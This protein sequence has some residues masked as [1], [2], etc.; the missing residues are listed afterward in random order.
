MS[1]AYALLALNLLTTRQLPPGAELHIRLTTPISSY[2]SRAG[3]HVDAV[4]IAPVVSNGEIV[5]PAGSLVSGNLKSVQRV[6]FGLVHELAGFDLEF[7]AITTPDGERFP[8]SAR[9]QEVENARERL[10]RDG[11]I[12]GYR[13]T[14]SL[15]YRTGGY[16]RTAITWEMHAALAVWAVK[17]LLLQV[18]EPEIYY[19]VG[20]ELTLALTG[21]MRAPAP[22]SSPAPSL[23]TDKD[24]AEIDALLEAV[25]ARTYAAYSN[26]PSDLINVMFIGS[27]EDVA[28]AFEAAGWIEPQQATLRTNIRRIRAVAD[29]R[30]DR[31]APMSNLLVQDQ[32]AD[33]SWQK[34]FNDVSQRHHIR[35]WMQTETWNGKPVWVGAATHD[36]DFA[37]WR[38]G[39]PM[40][41]KIAE[42]VDDE[43]DKVVNDLVF[44]TCA[45]LLDF[46]ERAHIPTFTHNATGDPMRTDTRLAIVQVK[47]CAAP[48][49]SLQFTSATLP[50]HGSKLQRF[51][52]R[53]ILSLRS[54]VIRENIYWRSYEGVRWLITAYRQRGGR[55]AQNATRRPANQE[56]RQGSNHAAF[57]KDMF[58]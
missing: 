28:T 29:G 32:K 45:S 11:G 6:G 5:L 54:D 58:R 56:S 41:H 27:R 35:I 50:L 57:L 7:T 31:T 26:R 44:T 8:L 2:S 51:A 47:S 40:T 23:L 53:E 48:A 18:P 12:R 33:M 19:P 37:F 4:L 9:V 24:R 49:I 16:I 39:T 25:P 22:E 43:R 21:P 38:R 15:S 10:T 3:E 17:T 34:G 14:S 1:F 36:I 13:P 55:G 46:P 20:V 42:N 52:R 30:G